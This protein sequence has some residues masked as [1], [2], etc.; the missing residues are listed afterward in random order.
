MKIKWKTKEIVKKLE[1]LSTLTPIVPP[2][3]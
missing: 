2:A 1:K 3:T